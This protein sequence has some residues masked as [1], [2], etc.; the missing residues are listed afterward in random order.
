MTNN[1][2][3]K[4][5]E[6]KEVKKEKLNV[7]G[8]KEI[9]IVGISRNYNRDGKDY[10]IGYDGNRFFLFTGNPTAK[11]SEDP[12]MSPEEYAHMWDEYL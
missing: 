1:V 4:K 7:E 2:N 11:P 8:L 12:V 6:V 9:K 5:P 3:I 10:Y